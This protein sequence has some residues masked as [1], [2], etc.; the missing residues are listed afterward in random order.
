MFKPSKLKVL[1]SRP[2]YVEGFPFEF[3][4]T[5]KLVQEMG[6]STKGSKDPTTQISTMKFGEEVA[7]EVMQVDKIGELFQ[8]M[9][10]VNLNMGNLILKVNNLKNRLVTGE[11]EKAILWEE[12][13][14]ERDFL[15]GYKHNVEIWRKKKAK[16]EHKI[17]IFIKK[18]QDENEEFKGSTTQL[19]SQDDE[20]QDL[21]L[22]F[23]IW[24]TTKRKWTKAL[25]M[26][27][28]QQEALG[29]QVKTLINE[30]KEN[31][32]ILTYLELVNLKNVYLL[33]SKELRKKTRKA[34]KKKLLEEKKEYQMILQHL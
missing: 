10:I 15:K 24:E 22:K 33:Q 2:K 34:D 19:K 16:V 17:K 1:I 25:F 27:K 13:D 7:I 3:E 31:E 21:R 8:T 5:N 29:N 11:K 12:L 18:L 26:Y 4:M 23:K 20:L 6:S 14:K 28:Q 9:V 32:N 30:K